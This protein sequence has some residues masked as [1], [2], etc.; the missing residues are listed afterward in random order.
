VPLRLPRRDVRTKLLPPLA[1]I[2]VAAGL[3]LSTGTPI[4][5][6]TVLQDPSA[7][8]ASGTTATTFV[9]SVQYVSDPEARPALSATVEVV[10]LGGSPL[11][12]ALVAGDATNGTWETSTMLPAGSWGLVFRAD[13]S[14]SDP[15][16]AA[17][18][19]VTVIDAATPTPAPSS[20]PTAAPTATVPPQPTPTVRPTAVPTPPPPGVTPA[21]TPTPEPGLTAPSST[22]ASER[23]RS[24]SSERPSDG[25]SIGPSASA[26]SA[27][28]TGAPSSY[29]A[30][31]P[32][33]GAGAD[34]GERF[35]RAGWVVVGGLTSAAG[36]AVLARQWLLRR[37]APSG[38]G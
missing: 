15:T 17:G 38:A 20:A 37:R 31:S 4:G 14:G 3:L 35:G 29:A 6:A 22:A 7:T 13:A 8:P 2:L 28:A 23:P 21:A 25:S 26:R 19:T 11:P 10:G 12:M 36:A 24:S 27:P 33:P 34:G 5:A 32:A 16:P 9:L 1:A 30:T 18:P